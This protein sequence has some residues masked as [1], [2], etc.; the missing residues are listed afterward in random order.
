MSNASIGGGGGG[1]ATVITK[2]YVVLG[3]GATGY[4][5]L[6]VTAKGSI[7]VGDGVDDPVAFAVGANGEILTADSTQASGLNWTTVAGTGDVTASA[8]L[9]DNSLIR[10]DGGAKGV[11]DSGIL[12]DDTDNLSGVASV[13]ISLGGDL[14]INST[15]VLNG[16]TLGSG[17]TASS[18]TS[19]GT[20]ATGTWEGTT[21]A[22]NQGGSGQTSYTNGQL[23]IGNT[24]GNT[25][26]KATLTGTAN[27]IDVTNGA[28]SITLALSDTLD[29][30]GFTSL[31]I[32]NSATPTVNADGEIA[33]DTTVTDFSHG[34]M[35]YYSGEEAGVVA[36]P[37][38]EFTSPTDGHVVTYNATNDEFE[39]AAG[40]SG[41]MP[42]INVGGSAASHQVNTTT[43]FAPVNYRDFGSIE[44]LVRSFNTTTTEYMQGF[45]RVPTD[46]GA[47][48]SNVTFEIVGS[49]STAAASKNVKFTFDFVQVADSGLMTGA[50]GSAEIW[51]DQAVSA[52]QDDQDIISNTETITNLG[53]VAGRMVYYRLYRSTATTN[54]LATD[55]DV[56]NFNILI[57]QA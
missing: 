44:I 12:I 4:T 47:G 43:A 5:G 28:G 25:L 20:I 32:P 29:L 36:M 22:V 1:T 21:I 18:L 33:I 16:T 14:Q 54:N 55:Y 11:Q 40:G 57:P 30:G 6:D 3:N 42:T 7:L 34:I 41:S 53:W 52:T 38:A 48:A 31:E 24:T 50:Y 46:L 51:D 35:K 10:G 15:S 19:V 23:L 2:G 17:V 27:E 39:L 49:A 26:A 13:N 8:V 56:I 45:F 9:A 37:I